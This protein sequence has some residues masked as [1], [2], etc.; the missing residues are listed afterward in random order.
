MTLSLKMAALTGLWPSAVFS[1]EG[2]GVQHPLLPPD[3]AFSGRCPNCGMLRAMW[4][5]TWKTF[6]NTEGRFEACSFHCLADMTQK[7]GFAPA[8][9]A[10]ALYL[11]PG[12]MVDARSAVYVIG[13]KAP[14]TMTMN[15]KP[16]FAD[17]SQAEAFRQTCG[18]RV[19]GYPEALELA[20]AGLAK[21]RAMIDRKRLESGKIVDPVDNRDE[22]PVC[23]MFPARY[24]GNKCQLRSTEDTVYHFCSTQCLFAFLAAPEKYVRKS[25][26]PALIW[27]VD[28]TGKS[29][30]SAWTAYFVVGSRQWGP[31]GHEAFAFDRREAAEGFRKRNGGTLL[32]FE[33]VTLA[34]IKPY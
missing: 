3:K 28:T 30:I 9:P 21:E 32:R 4:A 33:D 34:R 12:S 7:S 16:A 31:M 27:V 15:S 5:R 2:C 17:A 29:W 24:P 8:N 1:D 18:G 11:D 13:S 25:V 6:E 26:E 14:G 22:C 19:A 10:T 20:R 23:L